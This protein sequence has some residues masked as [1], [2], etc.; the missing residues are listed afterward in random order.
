MFDEP[1]RMRYFR[2]HALHNPANSGFHVVRLRLYNKEYDKMKL[3][4]KMTLQTGNETEIK[5]ALPL[6]A[7]LL[8]LS[9]RLDVATPDTIKK[10]TTGNIS[11]LKTRLW[12]VQ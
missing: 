7:R 1:V 10:E 8:N 2:I 5:D 6:S 4:E 3:G 12:N 9:Q 11:V